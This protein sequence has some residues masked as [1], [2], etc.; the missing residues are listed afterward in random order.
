MQEQMA[1][2][3]TKTLLSQISKG[4]NE[5]ISAGGFFEKVKCLLLFPRR[6]GGTELANDY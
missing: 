6:I 5:V 1:K 3:S 2:K 4:K